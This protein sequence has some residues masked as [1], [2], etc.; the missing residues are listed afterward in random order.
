M[1]LH[2]AVL[3]RHSVRSYLDKPLDPAAVAELQALISELNAG[4]GL[5][6]QLML[7]E[8]APFDGLLS[9]IGWLAGVKNYLAL[10]GPDAPDLEEKCGY[11]GER[12]VLEAQMRGIN[13]CWVGG[14]YSKGKCA[15][16]VGPG[17]KLALVV[18]LGYGKN[19]GKSRK[20]KSFE[21]VTAA[22]GNLP[23][24]FRRGVECALLAPTAI[25]QQAFKFELVGEDGVRATAGRGAFAKVDLGIV[26]YHFEIGAGEED[27]KWVK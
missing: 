15:A 16:Q 22:A 20:S 4:S 2:E 8:S 14:T 12:F 13:S 24:W 27:W 6:M 23:E 26:K 19:A 18:A 21:A 3:A 10:V 11:Y 9:K 25:N 17:E 7:N 1:N 5:R